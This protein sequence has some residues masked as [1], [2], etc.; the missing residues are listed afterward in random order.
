MNKQPD[1]AANA[2]ESELES[3]H[4]CAEVVV[5]IFYTCSC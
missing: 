4:A 5:F 2:G 1:F 3:H